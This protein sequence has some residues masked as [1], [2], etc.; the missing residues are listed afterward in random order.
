MLRI[1]LPIL[2]LASPALADAGIKVKL[3]LK[4]GAEK[5]AYDLLIVEQTCGKSQEKTTDHTDEIKVCAHDIQNNNVRLDVD[6][7]TLQGQNDNTGHTSIIVARNSSAMVAN[8]G[9]YRLD[10]AVQ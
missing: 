8:T 10:V 1:A 6:W 4:A 5:R 2:L 7:M 9:T 3:S